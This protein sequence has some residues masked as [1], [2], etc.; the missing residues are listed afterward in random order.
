MFNQK[1]PKHLSTNRYLSNNALIVHVEAELT[2]A[3]STQ[4]HL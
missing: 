1:N 3:I 2:Q 4:C